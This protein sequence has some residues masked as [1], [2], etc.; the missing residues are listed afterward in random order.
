VA[1][2]WHEVRQ[3]SA[4]IRPGDVRIAVAAST[5]VIRP[6][7]FDE[8]DGKIVVVAVNSGHAEREVRLRGLP[9]GVYGVLLTA[10]ERSG[11]ESPP[12]KAGKG[13]P[14][15]CRMPAQAI[16]TFYPAVGERAA[17]GQ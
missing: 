8:S 5:P 7:A 13:A 9:E 3:C 16:T 1:E 12:V 4:F 10:P 2:H 6:V 11:V 15:I 17:A 14:L